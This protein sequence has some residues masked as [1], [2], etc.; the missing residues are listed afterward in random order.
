MQRSTHLYSKEETSQT[1]LHGVFKT[2]IQVP[3]WYYFYGDFWDKFPK[4]LPFMLSE[5]SKVRLAQNDTSVAQQ[6]LKQSSLMSSTRI[7]YITWQ[8]HC[9]K[10]DFIKNL[11]YAR[12]YT[13]PPHASHWSSHP[14]LGSDNVYCRDN[15]TKVLN[16][17]AQGHTHLWVMEGDWNVCL[18]CCPAAFLCRPGDYAHILH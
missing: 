1:L 6:G 16:C 12:H 18:L 17:L 9:R 3:L 10:L 4:C 8:G 11:L 5:T 2:R 13:G 15:E 7:L 14:P